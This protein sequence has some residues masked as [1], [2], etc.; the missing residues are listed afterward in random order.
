MRVLD[1]P[2]RETESARHVRDE[3]LPPCRQIQSPAAVSATVIPKRRV[4]IVSGCLY[5]P[6]AQTCTRSQPVAPYKLH[7]SALYSRSHSRSCALGSREDT[8]PLMSHARTS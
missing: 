8:R 7:N 5:V 2:L 6:L 1:V 4:D 3:W